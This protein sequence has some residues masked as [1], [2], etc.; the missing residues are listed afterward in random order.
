MP[1]AW[2]LKALIESQITLRFSTLC[3]LWRGAVAAPHPSLQE[4]ELNLVGF[5]RYA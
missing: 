5:I 1:L 3:S 2:R 4:V